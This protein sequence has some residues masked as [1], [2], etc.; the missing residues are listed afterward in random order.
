MSELTGE[1]AFDK[2][3]DAAMTARA[4]MMREADKR[5]DA[6]NRLR[7]AAA[8]ESDAVRLA[9]GLERQKNEAAPKLS[10]LWQASDAL[11]EAATHGNPL[12][13]MLKRLRAALDAAAGPCDQPP[14]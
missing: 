2:V 8:R 4:D 5:H 3:L 1:D 7:D 13:D 10:E 9:Q 6:E 11:A 14:F 12:P